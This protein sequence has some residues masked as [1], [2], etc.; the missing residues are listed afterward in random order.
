MRRNERYFI[1]GTLFFF[2]CLLS[3]N[4]QAQSIN[5]SNPLQNAASQYTQYYS[6]NAGA[7]PNAHISPPQPVDIKLSMP[8]MVY[9][10]NQIQPVQFT[11]YQ[12]SPTYAGSNSL[13]IK[14]TTDWTQ[15]AAVPVGANVS[16]LAIS[17]NGGSGILSL[18]DASGQA[19]SYNYFFYPN[20]QLTFYAD[21]P[22]RHM[23]TY[24]IGGTPSNPVVIDVTGT[25]TM[26][27]TPT[28]SY[29]PPTGSYPVYYNPYSNY[30]NPQ[31]ELDLAAANKAYQKAI[32]NNNYYNGSLYYGND[33]L[34]SSGYVVGLPY[35]SSSDWTYGA[36][37]WLNAP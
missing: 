33:W 36:Y 18:V 31:A 7:S 19:Y 21:A 9:F 24:S 15:Y 3:I 14:G 22:G 10:G 26:T 23:L 6:M 16:L 13:W 12:S 28:Q 2:A 8:N 30:A 1:L 27:Y 34:G 11:Q 4:A 29:Y 37:A 35:Y 20:S 17:P 5:V 25:L 32:M